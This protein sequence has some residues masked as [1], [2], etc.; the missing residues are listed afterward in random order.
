MPSHSG[1]LAAICLLAGLGG[2]RGAGDQNCS[3]PSSLPVPRFVSLKFDEVNA[4]KGP[5]EDY[6]VVWV[7]HGKGMPVKVIAETSDWRKIQ[8]ADGSVAWVNK[9]LV[10]GRR[11]VLRNADSRADLRADPKDEARIVAWLAPH[12]IA[13]LEKC[14]KGWC[15][16]KASHV[17]GWI[18]QE[19]VWGGGPPPVCTARR[20]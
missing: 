18:R 5:G 7:W 20:G 6:D 12:A 17:T 16:V 1:L 19:D 11:M 15:R 9:R 10:D 3:T 4:R 2:C 13:A 14:E 8:A